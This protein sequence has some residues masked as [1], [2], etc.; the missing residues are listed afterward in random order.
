MVVSEM[1]RPPLVY[2]HL[3]ATLLALGDVDP[4]EHSL[5]MSPIRALIAD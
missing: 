4:A 2:A 3:C 1:G 5:E